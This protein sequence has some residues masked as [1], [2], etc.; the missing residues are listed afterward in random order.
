MNNSEITRI[1]EKLIPKQTEFISET[2]NTK[3]LSLRL[4]NQRKINTIKRFNN[5]ATR[6]NIDKYKY[7][8]I[9]FNDKIFDIDV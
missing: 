8:S 6:R 7:Y 9:F 3:K 1:Y 5:L 2:N 4:E